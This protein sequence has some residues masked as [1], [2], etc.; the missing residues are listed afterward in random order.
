MS[1]FGFS[2]ATAGGLT[3]QS[4]PSNVDFLVEIVNDHGTPGRDN[5]LLRSYNNLHNLPVA[6]GNTHISWQLD[7]DTSTALDSTDLPL[8]PPNL[9]DFSQDF[10]F[11]MTGSL[12]EFGFDYFLV[13][14]E[15]TSAQLNPSPEPA[16]PE[17]STFVIWF[18]LAL[19]LTDRLWWAPFRQRP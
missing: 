14:G 3:M 19:T 2:T 7:D 6:L 13:R 16:I 8:L 12:D 15:I 17:P 5:Y 9:A 4:D 10:G 18:M 11:T 1:P